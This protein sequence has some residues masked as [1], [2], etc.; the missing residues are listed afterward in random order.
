MRLGAR[1]DAPPPLS[2]L[3]RRH[4]AVDLRR[5]GTWT[6]SEAV[7]VIEETVRETVRET[8][9]LAGGGRGLRGAGVARGAG[10]DA[11]GE[12]GVGVGG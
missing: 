11:G 12:E 8:R 3:D 2:L 6:S 1:G 4:P 7:G 10:G 9:E 5:F